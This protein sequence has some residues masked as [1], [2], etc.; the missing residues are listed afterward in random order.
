ML[1][2]K[3]VQ[4]A[5]ALASTGDLT[6]SNLAYATNLVT[7]ICALAGPP[8]YLHDLRTSA[9]KTGLIR[10]VAAHDTPALFEW[11]VSAASFQGISDSVAWVDGA[12]PFRQQRLR[13]LPPIE[14]CAAPAGDDG[15]A[16]REPQPQPAHRRCL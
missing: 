3:K 14:A 16:K 4:T 6:G 10:A 7:T 2:P 12:M 11:F 15:N 5:V 8:N 9:R 1:R 13:V